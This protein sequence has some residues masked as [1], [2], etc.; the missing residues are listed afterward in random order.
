MIYYIKGKDNVVDDALIR[1]PWIFSLIPLRENLREFV[2]E[3]LLGYSW[4]IKVTSIL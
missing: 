4:Y 1:R 3:K 2:I